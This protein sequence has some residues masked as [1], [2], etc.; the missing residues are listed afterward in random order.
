MDF[1]GL[2]THPYLLLHVRYDGFNALED[3]RLALPTN[4]QFFLRNPN[5]ISNPIFFLL[6]I[7]LSRLLLA[8]N[9][10]QKSKYKQKKKI[11]PSQICET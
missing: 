10:I 4:H 7:F 5:R 9:S 8:Y 2:Q 1:N 3:V 6:A 11:S